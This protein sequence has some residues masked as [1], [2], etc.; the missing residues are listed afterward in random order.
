MIKNGAIFGTD[1]LHFIYPNAIRSINIHGV[2]A[3]WMANS[4]KNF[5]H[6]ADGRAHSASF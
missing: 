1:S 2:I 4:A 3:Y 6:C 5:C